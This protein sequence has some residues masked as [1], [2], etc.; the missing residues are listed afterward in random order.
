[1]IPKPGIVYH[2]Q[3]KEYKQTNYWLCV[4]FSTGTPVSYGSIS[5]WWTSFLG[6]WAQPFGEVLN[7]KHHSGPGSQKSKTPITLC[8]QQ[9]ECV[10]RGVGSDVVPATLQASLRSLIL[11]KSEKE[12]EK[13]ESSV[14]WLMISYL[15][16]FRLGMGYVLFI[17]PGPSWP[18]VEKWTTHFEYNLCLSMRLVAVSRDVIS[19]VLNAGLQPLFHQMIRWRMNNLTFL[20]VVEP[21]RLE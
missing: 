7:C 9:G 8:L 21:W 19:R 13:S 20:E 17:Q 4:H 18:L 6:N 1:M 12:N 15:V 16:F 5:L 3:D 11:Q 14:I 10:L 2:E